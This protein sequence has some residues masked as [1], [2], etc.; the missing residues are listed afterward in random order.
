VG[1]GSRFAATLGVTIRERRVGLGLSQA[2]IGRPLGRAYVSLVENGRVS[3]SLGSLLLIAERLDLSAW[4]LLRMVH[5]RMT[6]R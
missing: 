5:N 1:R 2:Q 4:E 6:L 3:P